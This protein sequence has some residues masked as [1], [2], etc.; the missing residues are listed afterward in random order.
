MITDDRRLRIDLD[1]ARKR[2]IEDT[3]IIDRQRHT[4][5]EQRDE[6]AKQRRANRE[7]LRQVRQLETD[8]LR[9]T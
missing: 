9:L 4:L 5:T 6:L 1:D 8:K 2:I 3:D 7:L